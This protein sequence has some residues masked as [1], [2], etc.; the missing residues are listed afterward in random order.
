MQ[1]AASALMG[2]SKVS[3]NDLQKYIPIDSTNQA[4]SRWGMDTAKMTRHQLQNA[5]TGTSVWQLINGITNFASN[6]KG[7][8]LDDYNR[9]T[10]MIRSGELL[11]KKQFDTE[12]LVLS[13]FDHAQPDMGDK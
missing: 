7:D 9:S 4:F 2:F 11:T 13:P 3:Y 12:N 10:L 6:H 8:D 1:K 5:K